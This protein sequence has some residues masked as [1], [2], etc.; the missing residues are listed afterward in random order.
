MQ[1]E[2]R[3]PG[4]GA[5][6]S[7]YSDEN[8]YT[9][10]GHNNGPFQGRNMSRDH[11]HNNFRNNNL[12]NHFDNPEPDPT[13]HQAH[14]F[15]HT[16][17]TYDPKIVFMFCH[18][19]PQPHFPDPIEP[20][21]NQLKTETPSE[22]EMQ[23]EMENDN[24][25]QSTQHPQEE[26]IDKPYFYKLQMEDRQ[27]PEEEQSAPNILQTRK[28]EPGA[29]HNHVINPTFEAFHVANTTT[30]HCIFDTHITAITGTY[31]RT[32]IDKATAIVY[33]NS[34]IQHAGAKHFDTRFYFAHNAVPKKLIRI[35]LIPSCNNLADV[36][37]NLL[38]YNWLWHLANKHPNN[39]PSNHCTNSTILFMFLYY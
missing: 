5:Y 22:G 23:T 2:C 31:M 32:P 37:T 7:R 17:R 20:Y 26:M 39:Q 15:T 34:P 6:R 8:Q 3:K 16:Q 36:Y 14:L 10:Q 27:V 19:M 4:G 11:E 18:S 21:K 12:T 1:R 24:S 35:G 13:S 28:Q 30:A 29:L 9:N 38:M 33:L 25:I